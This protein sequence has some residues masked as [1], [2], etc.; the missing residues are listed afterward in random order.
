MVDLFLGNH[1]NIVS[2]IGAVTKSHRLE[3]LKNGAGDSTEKIEKNGEEVKES[4][5]DIEEGSRSSMTVP[6]LPNKLCLVL[7]YCPRGSL[8]DC[9]IKCREKVIIILYSMHT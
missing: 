7:E 1:P 2:F 4:S 5:K 8:F 6:E 3:L 9:L